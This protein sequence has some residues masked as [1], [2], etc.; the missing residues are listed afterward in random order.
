MRQIETQSRFKRDYKREKKSDPKLDEK[1][2]PVLK[3]LATDHTLPALE[4]GLAGLS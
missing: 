4:R 3:M 2:N 1:L